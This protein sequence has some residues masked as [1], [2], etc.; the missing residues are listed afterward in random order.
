MRILIA[1][2]IFPPQIGGP[3]TYSKLV[4]DELPKRGVDV[5]IATFGDYIHKPKLVRHFL[6][7]LELL[8]KASEADIIYAMD[9]VSVGL[10]AL[11]A[12]QIRRKKL[13]LKVVGDYAWEQGTQRFGVTDTLDHFARNHDSHRWQVR[14]LKWIEAY[15]ALGA[16][17]VITPSKYLK[18]IL[19]DWG[20]D[21][22]D[23]SVIYNGFHMEPVKDTPSVLRKKMRWA[24]KVIVTV[25]RLVPW[26]GI[27]EVIESMSDVIAAHPDARLVV[28]GDGPDGDMLKSRAAE[29][30]LGDKVVF[31]GRLPQRTMFE[32]VK[33]ADLFV[34]NT[35]YEGFSHQ[36]IETMALGTPVITTAVGGNVEIIRNGENGILI[37]P[38]AVQSLRD[39]II[40][41]LGDSK[42]ADGLARKAKKDVA[43][44]TDEI[45]LD[46]LADELKKI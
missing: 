39:A 17:R 31:T 30:G 38:G 20:I 34:L 2:G 29:L 18:S 27:K 7:F 33:A 1:T 26:K 44:F 42:R 22:R 35:A 13:V 40:G 4:Y 45:M 11:F 41:L 23:I 43:L 8:R 37:A 46:R 6:Y 3:A 5:E 32:Y 28:V 21:S 36:I 10:P 24:G 19:V 16:A 15:V 14:I 12:A 9:P 25:G